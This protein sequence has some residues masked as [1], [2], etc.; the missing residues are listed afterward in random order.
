[1]P[2]ALLE[3]PWLRVG[4]I[5][6]LEPRRLAR[7]RSRRAWLDARRITRRNRAA[8][9]MRQ[10][11]RVGKR[12]RI[13]VVTEGVFHAQ[14]CRAIRHSKESPRFV[15]RVSRAQ[16]ARRHTGSLLRSTRRRT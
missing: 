3:E 5:I 1:V 12:T 14:M 15:R 4:Q 13:E 7:A 8:T 11:T 2:I 16:P 9:A 10:E 6:M